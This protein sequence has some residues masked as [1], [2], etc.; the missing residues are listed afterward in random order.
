MRNYL[1]LK[2]YVPTEGVVS[3]KVIYY[4]NSSPLLVDKLCFML[5]NIWSNYQT[6]TVPLKAVDTIGNFQRLAFTVGVSQHMPKITNLCKFQ[7]NRSPKLRD[8]DERKITLVT[9]SC[10]RS[11]GFRDLKF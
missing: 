5:T 10:V 2:K 7:L 4:E 11:N 6:C 8:N 9:R 3:H 1:F